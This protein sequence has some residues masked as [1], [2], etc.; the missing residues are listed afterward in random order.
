MWWTRGGWDWTGVLV[1]AGWQVLMQNGKFMG[2]HWKPRIVMI[3]TLLS[4]VAPEVVFMTTNQWW[5]I[6]HRHHS[7]FKIS[8]AT[9][10]DTVGIM[11]I[12]S[13][14]HFWLK[15]YSCLFLHIRLWASQHRFRSGL[16][17]NMHYTGH[18][19]AVCTVG[20]IKNGVLFIPLFL[21]EL[22]CIL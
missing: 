22:T 14:Q 1:G 16:S 20:G 19:K 15:F 4:L 18:L 2:V 3:A 12:L 5:Q 9:N 17:L 7:W 10:D 6:W 11:T 8:S 13:F 21:W